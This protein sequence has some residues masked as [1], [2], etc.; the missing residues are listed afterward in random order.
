MSTE[1]E[2][3][4][5][6]IATCEAIWLK[7]LLKDLQVEVSDPTTIYYANLNNIQFVKNPI[8]HAQT[9]HIEVHYYFV[10]EQA[11]SDEVELVY[12]LTDWQN[13]DIFTKPLG[14][15]KLRQF[16]G[17]LGL[18]HFDVPNLRGRNVPDD[19]ER[20]QERSGKDLGSA[21]E[22]ESGSA[23]ES[24]SGH[25]GSSRKK[26]P[27]P[28]RHGGDDAVKG[29][30]TGD[31]LET[32]NSDESSDESENRSEVT[33]LVRMFDSDTLNQLR[34]K[35]KRRQQEKRQHRDNK[36]AVKGRGSRQADRKGRSARSRTGRGARARR[37]ARRSR[38]VG[39]AEQAE[40]QVE[41]EGEC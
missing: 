19:H 26:E 29:E 16:S 36:G 37:G 14:L 41:L 39:P 27:K 5:V 21:E 8:D 3:R 11:L 13:A 10:R 18:R 31:E 7:R 35:R 20:E 40:P 32:A 24:E 38:S 12:V 28:T 34:A 15:D 6:V 9:K 25:K 33:E 4:G 22:A 30:K 1:A 23:E 2:Y 17:V